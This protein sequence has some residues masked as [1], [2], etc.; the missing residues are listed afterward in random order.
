MVEALDA[1]IQDVRRKAAALPKG[2]LREL[3][4]PPTHPTASAALLLQA[5]ELLADR[6]PARLREVMPPL[7]EVA[8][9]QELGR[10][11]SWSTTSP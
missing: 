6:E 8:S 10:S 1:H 11:G 5:D 9:V 3:L 4:E 7:A 2:R